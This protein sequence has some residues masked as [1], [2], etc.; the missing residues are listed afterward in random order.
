MMRLALAMGRT[1]R[2]LERTMDARE[3]AEWI[4]YD[5]IEGI[6]WP[7]YQTGVLAAGITRI[8]AGKGR[9]PVP[10]DYMPVRVPRA[11]TPRE[12]MACLRTAIGG[13]RAGRRPEPA[14]A[15]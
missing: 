3:L 11:Q 8:W 13:G 6:P 10:T 14:D 5:R 15:G 7:W 12:M 1:V 9:K 4:A 2:E